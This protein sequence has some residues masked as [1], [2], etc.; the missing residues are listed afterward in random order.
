M[1]DA[2]VKMSPKFSIQT[3][4][5]AM[6]VAKAMA[7]SGYFKDSQDASKALVKILAGQ[8]IGLGP[9]ASMTGVHI[10]QGKPVVGANLI[11]TIIE[12]DPRYDF[13][14]TTHN[15]EGCSIDFFQN[16]KKVGESSFNKTDAQAAGLLNKDTWQKYP[17]NMYFSRAISNGARWFAAGVFG[18][19]PIYTP[20]EMDV[21]VDEEGGMVIDV[22]A[23]EPEPD[24]EPKKKNGSRP[25][26]PATVKDRIV[27]KAS[28][29]KEF[30]PNVK[31]QKLLRYALALCFPG[32]DDIDDKRHTILQY[33]VGDPS[34]N[35]VT[36]Q[37]FN[38]IIDDWLAV[39]KDSGDEYTV[40]PVAAQEAQAIFTEALKDE[41]QQ[42]MEI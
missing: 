34:S 17:R 2:I 16:S 25:Y 24:P 8:E 14:I 21:E 10:I 15:N 39:S 28:R 38:A 31:Q 1:S 42:E 4:D 7:A 18:G 22:V 36:G 41:G 5:D 19:A 40:D 35:K 20:D 37:Y 3:F 11:A 13:R 6:N 32:A 27:T 33:L 30:D 29:S 9:F 12:D 26:S 23:S